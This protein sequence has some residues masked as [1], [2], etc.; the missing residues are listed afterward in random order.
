MITQFRGEY[1]WLSNMEELTVPLIDDY[2]IR[3]YSTE[4]YYQAGK[5]TNLEARKYIANLPPR[6]SKTEGRKLEVRKDWEDIKISVME[7][8]LNQ[9]FAIPMYRDLLLATGNQHIQE[10][11]TWND[12]F[13]GVCLKT[14]KGK[15]HLG[16]LLMN[17]RGAI[18]S[19]K[20]L[21]AMLIITD[22]ERNEMLSAFE[23]VKPL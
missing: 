14:G 3:Y 2:G 19:A 7:A 10:G 1:S 21:S 22:E 5:T 11:N 9:K 16:T 17:L 20:H 4:N 12:Q 6:K 23:G 15:N 13:W 18:Y 8:A